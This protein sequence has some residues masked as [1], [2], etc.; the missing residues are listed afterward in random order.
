MVTV[1]VC[2]ALALLNQGKGNIVLDLGN[3]Y[4]AN[5]KARGK[6]CGKWQQ[7]CC[8][9]FYR[10]RQVSNGRDIRKGNAGI[11][12]GLEGSFSSFEETSLV[13]LT[14]DAREKWREGCRVSPW[15]DDS[16]S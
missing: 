5:L 13:V 11:D 12:T 2:V 14:S 4:P 9:A 10:R 6:M 15:G 16:R 8:F 3:I 7:F 1:P